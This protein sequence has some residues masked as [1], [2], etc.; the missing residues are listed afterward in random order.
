MTYISTLLPYELE[1]KTNGQLK[2]GLLEYSLL[3]KVSKQAFISLE[4]GDLEK[5][6]ALVGENA[7]QIRAIKIA[8]IASRDLDYIQEHVQRISLTL[9]KV[10]SLLE[11]SSIQKLMHSGKSLKTILEENGLEHAL[12]SDDQFCIQSFILCEMREAQTDEEAIETLCRDPKLLPQKL[13]CLQPEISTSF[14]KSLASKMR[15]LLSETS[16]KFVKEIAEEIQ[17]TELFEI[18]STYTNYYN[19]RPCT[20]M[21]W[22]Y[23]TLLLMAQKERVPLIL[24]AKFCDQN[25]PHLKV[26]SE[27][28]IY[29]KPCPFSSKYIQAEPTLEELEAPACI[30]EGAVCIEEDLSFIQPK[31]EKTLGQHS[32]EDIIL[33]GAADH[34]QYPDSTI[35]LTIQDQQYLNYKKLAKEGGFSLENPKTFFI[36]HIYCSQ[37][38]RQKVSSF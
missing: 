2:K 37:T 4:E 6:D 18:L 27:K 16:V 14:L 29:F 20:P 38:G 30:V 36:R 22:T 9:A 31:W 23:K 33:A 28:A 19:T 34:R 13:K 11:E 24:K 25:D 10:S 35:E 3:L 1:T 26:V 7:C 15:K 8:L 5:F 32:I 21:F 12:S 17:N